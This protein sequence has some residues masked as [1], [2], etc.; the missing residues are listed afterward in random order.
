MRR[1]P[2]GCTSSY[3]FGRQLVYRQRRSTMPLFHQKSQLLQG[4][5]LSRH[6]NVQ[7][8]SDGFKHRTTLVY[9]LNTCNRHITFGLSLL[10]FGLSI[11]RVLTMILHIAGFEHSGNLRL[12]IASDLFTNAGILINFSLDLLLAPRILR[13][14]QSPQGRSK[15]YVHYVRHPTLLQSAYSS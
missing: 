7:I 1:W 15:V 2:I 9:E 13:A 3:T 10:L 5:L 6:A 12:M 4:L 14:E 8:H 11:A